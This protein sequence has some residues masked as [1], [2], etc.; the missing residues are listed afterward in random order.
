VLDPVLEQAREPV[1]LHWLGDM[2]DPELVGYWGWSNLNGATDE[3]LRLIAD[4]ADKVDGLKVSLLDDARE[5]RL[6]EALPDGVR[7][8]TGD[9]FNYPSLIAGGSDALL[10]IFDAIAPAAAAAL[11]A[12]DDGDLGRYDE[13]MA[14]TVPLSRKIFET[15]TYNYKTGIVFLAWLNGHQNAFNMINGAQA[16]RSIPHLSEVFRLADRAGLLVDPELAVY[17]MRSLLAVNGL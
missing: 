2:F 15:P 16:A 8:Y 7:L 9:D 5:I 11:Q 10:G 1:I 3:V 6:R 13:I 4:H 12:L 14:P 17:R